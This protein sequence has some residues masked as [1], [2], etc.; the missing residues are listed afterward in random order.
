MK[1]KISIVI[2]DDHPIFRNG[3][4]KIIEQEE[5]FNVAAE[6]GDGGAAL[7]YIIRKNPEIAVLDISMPVLS[8]LEIAS[9]TAAAGIDTMIIILTMYSDEEYLEEALEA[10]VRG[11]L[12]KESTTGEILDCI[13]SITNGGFFV[14]PELTGYLINNKR[15][16][17]DKEDLLKRIESLTPTERQV[18]KLLAENK[19]SSQIAAE[20]FISFRTV[21]NH[22]TNI[23][24]KLDIT[25][26]NKL[27]L[28]AL[29]N[30]SIL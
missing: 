9:R 5:G 19:T 4:K 10:G 12:L 15:Q 21:Q 6:F 3:L 27:F 14:S 1:K 11:Y 25:G 8:G 29:E 20:M 30:K 16:N 2:A 23:S 13:K 7:D 22:R 17:K 24:H 28:F 18:L 26:Y